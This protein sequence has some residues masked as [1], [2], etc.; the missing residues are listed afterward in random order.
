MQMHAAAP[1]MIARG[2]APPPVAAAAAAAGGP[3]PPPS[4]G[5]GGPINPWG[6]GAFGAA[7]LGSGY[8]GY[9]EGLTNPE[10]HTFSP[11]ALINSALTALPGAA[12]GGPRGAAL[13]AALGFLSYRTGHGMGRQAASDYMRGPGYNANTAN[14]RRSPTVEEAGAVL[15][16]S[17]LL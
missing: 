14:F 6:V 12:M 10:A 7:L 8:G 11:G 9:S 5:G 2:A 3:P 4:P 17:N 13:A 16:A 15:A 1:T